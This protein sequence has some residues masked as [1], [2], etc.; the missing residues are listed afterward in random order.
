MARD[1]KRN[2]IQKSLQKKGFVKAIESSDHEKY[3][4]SFKGKKYKHIVVKIS[5]GS[6]YKTYGINLLKLM[7]GRLCLDS[8]DQIYDLLECPM[9]FEKYIELL[10]EKGQLD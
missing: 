1:I 6:S 3:Y 4:F 2:K 5:R 8:N 7:K 10:K 9:D